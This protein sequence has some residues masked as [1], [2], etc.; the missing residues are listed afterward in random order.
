MPI[1]TKSSPNLFVIA[2]V[3]AS[4]IQ[5]S[6]N[7]RACQNHRKARLED[8]AMPTLT[9]RDVANL[10][11]HERGLFQERAARGEELTREE[12]E[13]YRCLNMGDRRFGAPS[14]ESRG[15]TQMTPEMIMYDLTKDPQYLSP[16]FRVARIIALA[17]GPM[18]WLGLPIFGITFLWRWLQS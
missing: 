2:P 15:Q 17:I 3:N 8:E 18:I 9:K 10:T 1:L 7:G 11:N 5:M 16:S 14:R 6:E 4:A 13:D 12:L